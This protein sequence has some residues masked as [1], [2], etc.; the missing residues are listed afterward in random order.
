MPVYVQCT[1]C[2]A[3]IYLSVKRK[4]QLPPVFRLKCPRCGYE[5]VYTPRNAVEEDVYGFTCPVCKLRFFVAQR[6]PLTVECPHCGSILRITSVHE[7]PI[8][9]KASSRNL[10]STVTATVLLGALLGA[11]TSKN[12]LGGAIAGGLIGALVGMLIDAFSEPEA[13]YIEE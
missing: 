11:A 7:E 1:R 6:P 2:G 8:V 5:D 12:K 13:K 3:K 10:T 9:V 4:S